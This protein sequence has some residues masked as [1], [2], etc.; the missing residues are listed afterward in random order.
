MLAFPT[1]GLQRPVMAAERIYVSYSVLEDSISVDALETYAK[2]GKLEGDLAAYSRYLDPQQLARLRRVLVTPIKLG[3]VPVS[4]FLYAPIGETLLQRLGKVIKTGA[5]QPGFY[6]LRAALI[7]AAADPDGLTLLNVLRKFPT[8]GIRLDLARSLEIAEELENFVNQT[9]QAIALVSQQ[10]TA[11]ATTSPTVDFS[12]LPDLRQRGQFTWNK[13]TLT[14]YDRQRDRRFQADLYL[15]N[16]KAATPV[17][18]ISH[19]LGSNRKTFEYL[20]QQLASYGFAV[21]VPEHPGSNSEQLRSLL[22]GRSDEVT[23][24]R[25]FIDRPLDVKYL[26]DE[27]ERLDAANPNL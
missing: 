15:P 20:A 16:I 26:L 21:A 9:N 10:S 19:G 12:Q 18:V 6:A 11:A 4:Q 22:A 13:Q 24:P 5:R 14:L 1:A 27:L 7:L 8:P 2:T 3:P 17:I 25:E 23:Q